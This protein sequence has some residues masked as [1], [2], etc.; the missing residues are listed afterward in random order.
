MWV[1]ETFKDF[2][3]T[4]GLDAVLVG[5]ASRLGR[6]LAAPSLAVSW[7]HLLALPESTILPPHWQA[8]VVT[9]GQASAVSL[10]LAFLDYLGDLPPDPPLQ[11]EAG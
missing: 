4:F 5:S 10:A 11:L 2:H 7:L 1:E 6:L 8:S 3:H 9:Y